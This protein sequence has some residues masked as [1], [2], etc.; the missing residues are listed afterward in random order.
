MQHIKLSGLHDARGKRYYKAH[1]VKLWTGDG[2]GAPTIFV[3]IISSRG[4][5]HF[6]LG[7]SADEARRLGEA[8]TREATVKTREIEAQLPES[9]ADDG[10]IAVAPRPRSGSQTRRRVIRCPD[11]RGEGRVDRGPWGESG[12]ACQRCSG[13]GKLIVGERS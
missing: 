10:S 3:D 9:I 5:P 8:L 11:C 13:L 4:V 12:G 7:L 1:A 2:E 6:A